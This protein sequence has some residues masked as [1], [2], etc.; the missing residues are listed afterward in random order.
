MMNKV[1][2]DFIVKRLAEKHPERMNELNQAYSEMI[3]AFDES[4]DILNNYFI[5]D[6][7]FNH[8]L[9]GVRETFENK[10]RTSYFSDFIFIQ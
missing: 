8:Q 6:V 7:D 5:A 10:T 2:K 4:Q 3:R 1:S 9:T